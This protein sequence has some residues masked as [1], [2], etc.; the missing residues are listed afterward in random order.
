MLSG[1]LGLECDCAWCGQVHAEQEAAMDLKQA[2]PDFTT[3]SNV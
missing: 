1:F 3:G 2:T